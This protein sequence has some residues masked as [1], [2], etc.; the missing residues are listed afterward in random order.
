LY[1]VGYSKKTYGD[2][3][4]VFVDGGMSD[5]IRPALY[6]AR[7]RADIANRMDEDKTMRYTVA[8]K[9]CES[10]DVLIHDISLPEVKKGD[11]LVVYTTGAYTYSMASN[12]NRIGKPGVLFVSGDKAKMVVKRET[13]DDLIRNDL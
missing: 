5:N 11:I 9:L 3:C 4:Y 2:K 8:G 12:Y 7:Y 1:T 6:Q 10:G 13:L